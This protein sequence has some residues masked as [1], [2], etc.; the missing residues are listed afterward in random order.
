[1]NVE[2]AVLQG[3]RARSAPGFRETLRHVRY[4]ATENPV[5]LG[6]F[7]LFFAFVALAVFGPSL[8]PYDPLASDTQVAL[9]PPSP[10]H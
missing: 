3:S 7:V 2:T 10:A 4:V 8:T 9:K 6:A 5:T 1:M